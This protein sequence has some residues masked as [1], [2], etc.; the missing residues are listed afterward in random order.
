MTH[1]EFL[2]LFPRAIQDYKPSAAALAQISKVKMLLVI[3]PFGVG[4][5]TLIDSLGIPFVPSDVT[6]QPRPGEKDGKDYFF[7]NDYDRIL[8]EIA[9]GS[10]I[11]VAISPDGEFYATRATSYPIEGWGTMAVVSEVVA[12]LRALGFAQVVSAF[13][14]PPSYDDWMQRL[15]AHHIDPSQLNSRLAEARRSF[16][17]ALT[18]S[19]THFILNDKVEP[20]TTQLRELSNN[21]VDP[22]RELA[23]KQAASQI[24]EVINGRAA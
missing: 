10:F 18:D 12:G 21:R 1:E 14:T 11:Q 5:T 19:A 2:Q 17:F 24:F 23:A 8:T 13:I 15:S 7:R 6:R 16:G 9:D 4:K 20:A 22:D 3:G